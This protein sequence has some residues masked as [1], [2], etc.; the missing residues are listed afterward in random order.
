MTSRRVLVTG[1][2]SGI[3]A[4]LAEAFVAHGARVCGVARRPTQ[5]EGVTVIEADLSVEADARRAVAAAV[6]ALGGLDA[7]VHAAGVWEAGPIASV[8]QAHVERLFAVNT[9][10]AFW[11]IS[12]VAALPDAG[13][14]SVVLIGSTAGQRGEPNHAAYAASKAALWGLV[15]SA[16][17][18]LAPRVRVNLVSPGWVRTPMVDAH[19]DAETEARIVAGIPNHRLGTVADCVGVCEFLMSDAASHLIGVDLPVSGGALL[20]VKAR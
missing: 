15:Q 20:P 6:A 2:T 18:E 7:V 4:G 17:Q 3:G 5:L 8:H 19:L 1:T 12:A 16:A 10:S 11:L 14:I 13:P 9:F